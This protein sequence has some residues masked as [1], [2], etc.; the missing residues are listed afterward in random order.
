MR[1]RP[2]RIFYLIE[3]GGLEEEFIVEYCRDNLKDQSYVPDMIRVSLL[4]D[5]FNFDLLTAFVEESNRYGE[6]PK[7]LVKLLNAKPEYS[8]EISYSVSV[9]ILDTVVPP[10][11]I[12]PKE[13]EINTT[14]YTFEPEVWFAVRE[15]NPDSDR[16]ESLLESGRP[17]WD[18]IH[19]LLKSGDIVFYN[20]AKHDNAPFGAGVGFNRYDV[21]ISCEPSDIVQFTP[22]GGVV[23]RLDGGVGVTLEKIKAKGYKRP[24]M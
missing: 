13:C 8:G 20:L 21:E 6:N 10:R 19:A 23:Y 9:R 5:I 18:E 4:F 14:I 3:F 15:D 16:I 7:S 17:D 12:T 2:G 24:E 11:S 1:N 22:S